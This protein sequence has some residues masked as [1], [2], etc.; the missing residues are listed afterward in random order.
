MAK[1]L[2]PMPPSAKT[3]RRAIWVQAVLVLLLGGAIW[4]GHEN[5]HAWIPDLI[6]DD[7]YRTAAGLGAGALALLFLSFLM[8]YQWRWVWLLI[9]LFEF[10][11]IGGLIF[12]GVK[13]VNWWVLSA[14]AIVPVVVLFALLGRVSRRW[15]HH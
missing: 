1:Q 5:R 7:I 14:L 13:H 4:F 8:R 10:A 11:S 2:N 3:A 15:F 6:A 9:L 12:S